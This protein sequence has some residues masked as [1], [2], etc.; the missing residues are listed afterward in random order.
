MPSVLAID[1]GTTGSP[2]SS[3][4]RTVA[5]SAADTASSPST[6]PSRAGWSTTPRR[7]PRLASRPRARR[8]PRRRAPRSALGIT[9]Q[10]ETVVLWDRTTLA[11]VAPR[12]RLAGSAHQPTDAASC[13]RRA[14]RRCS[15]SAPAWWPIPTSR[16]PSWS[17]CSATR[18]PA[19]RGAGRAGRRH[20]RQLAGA[21]LT[22]G[23]VHATDHTNASRT[24][25]YDIARAR[26]DA[27]LLALFGVPR[28][29]LPDVRAVDRR[30]RRAR[31]GALRLS[32]SRSP[33]S[34]AT[35]RPRS[36]ARAAAAAGMAKNTYGTGAF[37]LVHRGDRRARAARR[38][39]RD[40]GVRRA[41]RAGLRAGG[42]RLH[43]GRRGAVA[44][45]RA[46][47][48]R[49]GGGDRG[50]RAERAGHRRRLLRAGARRARRAALGAGGAGHHRRAHA[51][52]HAR[53]PRA[54]G[55]GGDGV[56]QRR[57]ARGDGGG[58]AGGAASACRCCGWTAAPRRTTG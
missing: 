23:A 36:S 26:L 25:L 56:Q 29:L 40:R 19:P 15:A 24:M 9:N 39:A 2:R 52:H 22:G 37:L 16:R 42:Q 21:R 44:P 48:H 31:R 41:G 50:A 20:G 54:R 45:R 12:H 46:R 8:S 34:P 5:C 38:R 1:Q 55:A 30:V 32:R 49:A 10:R 18:T 43:G 53:A 27:E 57:A 14:R 35:S 11:P 33:A 51:R 7:S 13:A 47:H 17:G 4:P 3:S 28:E 58:D 6:F